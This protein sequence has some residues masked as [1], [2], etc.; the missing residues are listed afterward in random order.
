FLIPIPLSF[1]KC[2][3][4]V[5]NVTKGICI[6]QGAD[7]LPGCPG[8]VT[9]T[10][11]VKTVGGCKIDP[12]ARMPSD[13]CVAVYQTALMEFNTKPI[14]PYRRVDGS[15]GTPMLI[16]GV[17]ESGELVTLDSDY[18]WSQLNCEENSW[19]Y[20]YADL[21]YKRYRQVRLV[22]V[23]CAELNPIACPCGPLPLPDGLFFKEPV[24]N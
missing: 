6:L 10:R 3:A 21:E 17:T 9:Y 19:L 1:S 22:A 23:S 13:S 15:Q 14:C 24:I 8:S 16:R 20:D 5:Y 18:K 11:F 7:D 2:L 4:V 12:M